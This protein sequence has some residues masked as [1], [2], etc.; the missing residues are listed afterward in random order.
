MPSLSNSMRRGR[1]APSRAASAPGSGRSPARARRV[2]SMNTSEPAGAS[3]GSRAPPITGI[4]ATAKA[5]RAQNENR[6]AR[7]NGWLRNTWKARRIQA[8]PSPG[9]AR[10]S[11]MA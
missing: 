1:P 9:S 5:A 7:P 2:A 10:S 11:F 6:P 8:S 4:Q 3:T